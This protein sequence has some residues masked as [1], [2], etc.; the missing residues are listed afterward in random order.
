MKKQHIKL[1]E[2][3]EKYLEEILSKGK[4]TAKKYKRATALL[5]MERGKTLQEIALTLGLNYNTVGQYRDKYNKEGL[6]FMED[7]PRP[8]RPIEIDGI[9][10]AK[11]TALACSEAPEGRA[12]WGLR[13]LAEK[14]VE[15]G[16]CEEISH[17]QVGRILK[18]TN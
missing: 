8:G 13:L 16:Y 18:K 10:R 17:M 7:L 4:L 1:K 2:E 15:L 3:D 5:E 6:K 11:I 14:V 9:Q 12:K